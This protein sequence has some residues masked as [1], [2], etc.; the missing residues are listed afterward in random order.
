MGRSMPQAGRRSLLLR[1]LAWFAGL[2][3]AGVAGLA[4]AAWLLKALMHA[5]GMR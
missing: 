2:W 3:A 1:R 4:V 5:A